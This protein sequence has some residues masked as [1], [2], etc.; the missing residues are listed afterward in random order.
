M[1]HVLSDAVIG[2][3]FDYRWMINYKKVACH[4]SEYFEVRALA[5]VACVINAYNE[6]N[7]VTAIV[8]ILVRSPTE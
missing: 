6:N 4:S 3:L 7:C 2:D 1:Q 5:L 8:V